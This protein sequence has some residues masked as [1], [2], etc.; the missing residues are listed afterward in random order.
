[1]AAMAAEVLV[2]PVAEIA[3]PTQLQILVVAVAGLPLVVMAME[4]VV[5]PALSLFAIQHLLPQALMQF[6]RFLAL[7]ALALR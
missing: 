4:E 3:Q 6:Q 2:Q 1:M 5:D 7:L